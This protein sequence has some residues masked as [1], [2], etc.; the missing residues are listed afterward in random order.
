[1]KSV[2]KGLYMSFG[3]FCTIPLPRAGYWD[4]SGAKHMIAWFPLV[5]AVIG[6]LW[7]AAAKGFDALLWTRW[8]AEPLLAGA[9]MLVPFFFSGLIH[10][11]GYMD[12]SDAVL[13]RRPL[14][15][16][17]RILK[18]SHVGA[19]AVIMI[20]ALFILLYAA[21]L[22]ILQR[23]E[24]LALLIVI[25]IV[26]RCFSALSVLCVRP[27]SSEGYVGIFKPEKPVPHRVMVVAFAV[28]AFVSAWL[29]AE[30]IGVTVAAAVALGFSAAMLY[31][32]KSFEFK[33]VSGDLA[34]F[35]LVI[36]EL[37]GL[38]ALAII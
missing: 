9:L 17:M 14:E 3:M 2:F 33:G 22:S 20:V 10:L 24:R 31:A 7:W 21:A 18:D 23:G 30:W 12:T 32:L 36:S 37:C 19:F 28:L 25:P 16:K 1:M 38:I 5:G 27:M 11:D 13:S 26:S 35:S 29:I 6:V 8:N 34:G 15:E 4:E